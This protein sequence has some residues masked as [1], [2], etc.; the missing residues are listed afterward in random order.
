M[1]RKNQTLNSDFTVLQI[2][3]HSP[4][5]TFLFTLVLAIFTM[6][7]VGNMAMILLIYLDAQ[8]HMPIYFLISQ[9]SLMDLMIICT[10]VPKMAVNFLSGRKSITLADCGAQIFFY[11]SLLGSECL[12]LTIMSY[13][14][15][16]AICQPLRYTH[17]IR[18]KICGLMFT[19]SW[20]LRSIDELTDG[21]VTFSF[22]YCGSRKIAHF[23]CDFSA[24]LIHSCNATST[25]EKN[26]FVCCI[27]MIGFP[28]EV[29]LASYT[30][31]ILAVISMGD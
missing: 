16:A 7:C 29:I 18:P 19:F 2:F 10:I 22:S 15:Y 6:E 13:D 17:L 23:F 9:L 20:I 1:A 14:H 24:F 27:V 8:L 30:W 5:H 25:F 28:V 21:V 3:D 11:V 31:I 26:S 4:T 12:L